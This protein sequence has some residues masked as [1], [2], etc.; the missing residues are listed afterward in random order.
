MDLWQITLIVLRRWYVFI[1][2]C[3]LTAFAVTSVSGR[4][5]PEYHTQAVVQIN[6]PTT[7][8]HF[9]DGVDVP[10]NPWLEQGTANTAQAM[11]ILMMSEALRY[12]V[13]QAGGSAS[14]SSA[15][16]ARS[17]IMT[18]DIVADTADRARKTSALI[19]DT[20]SGEL[21]RVQD[22]SRARRDMR[23]SAETLVSGE[24]PAQVQPGLR[25]EQAVVLGLGLAL[26][27]G[28]ALILDA[29]LAARR[30]R[31]TPS[32]AHAPLTGAPAQTYVPEVAAAPQAQQPQL[33][34]GV[35][36]VASA[37]PPTTSGASVAPPERRVER[38]GAR[39][40]EPESAP[41]P[42]QQA[43]GS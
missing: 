9:A 3:V 14:Y 43:V 32:W 22:Q 2:V 15:V 38:R 30:R 6:G 13:L 36:A 39:D 23:L 11:Q 20:V 17:S 4:I 37:T 31:R 10:V 16:R 34:N 7:S 21:T 5:E 40:T 18:F 35:P 33:A 12:K 27:V 29:L 25:K 28:L 24:T 19:P 26:A 1:P 8:P 41:E 42:Q